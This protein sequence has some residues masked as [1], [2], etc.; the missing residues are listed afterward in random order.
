M[1]AN[2][3]KFHVKNQFWINCI[4][5][6]ES[7]K[8]TELVIDISNP[9]SH[10]SLH[11]HSWKN[12]LSDLRALSFVSSNGSLVEVHVMKYMAD[13]C[14]STS[15]EDLHLL[16]PMDHAPRTVLL[17]QMNLRRL[18]LILHRSSGKNLMKQIV[19]ESNIKETLTQLSLKAAKGENWCDELM[20]LSKLTKLELEVETLKNLNLPGHIVD[21]TIQTDSIDLEASSFSFP[22]VK[23]LRIAGPQEF[24]WKMLNCCGQNVET[25]HLRNTLDDTM[26]IDD[27]DR[28]ASIVLP[29]LTSLSVKQIHCEATVHALLQQLSG[30]RVRKLSINE[31]N[32]SDESA[33]AN[34]QSLTI[35][36]GPTTLFQ[37]LPPSVLHHIS[38]V[39]FVDSDELDDDTFETLLT[40]TNLL[41]LST[42]SVE[43]IETENFVDLFTKLHRLRNIELDTAN[44][45]NFVDFPSCSM[46]T[47]LETACLDSTNLERDGFKSFI[48]SMPHLT[49]F[50]TLN[51]PHGVSHLI[52][53]VVSL[54]E[55]NLCN[56]IEKIQL[57]VDL[58]ENRTQ[59]SYSLPVL[60][61]QVDQVILFFADQPTI[62]E[63]IHICLMF[64]CSTRRMLDFK[65]ERK[66]SFDSLELNEDEKQRYGFESRE[67]APPSLQVFSEFVYDR[68]MNILS[69]QTQ[70]AN[71]M[72]HIERILSN[73]DSNSTFTLFV[74]TIYD[75]LSSH[76]NMV[77]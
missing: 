27:I 25:L 73:T 72:R 40:C 75:R 68:F 76:G 43:L 21:L 54:N 44:I 45:P 74:K 7:L 35:F 49:Q 9:V 33:L 59:L 55:H 48:R 12:V 3:S 60:Q 50:G 29:Q 10:T 11:C 39:K 13:H 24:L 70:H 28:L 32:Y 63:T 53:L 57:W 56:K 22:A 64:L 62:N 6:C 58:S 37:Y 66:F 20:Q 17:R 14:V 34:I 42:Y 61:K 41:K 77:M 5:G 26:E 2:A 8:V 36:K 47:N 30:R 19:C 15:I 1:R 16:C 51:Y 18:S 67:M 52:D 46:S 38:V 4:L 71:N 69:N 31:C 23:K 65:F